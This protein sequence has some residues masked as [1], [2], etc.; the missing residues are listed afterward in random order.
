MTDATTPAARMDSRSCMLSGRCPRSDVDGHTVSGP[1]RR[2]LP[3]LYPPWPG[4][5]HEKL[6]AP[7]VR[8]RPTVRKISDRDAAYVRVSSQEKEGQALTQ[9]DHSTPATP[10]SDELP[11]FKALPDTTASIIS[12][13]RTSVCDVLPASTPA[14]VSTRVSSGLRTKRATTVKVSPMS[15]PCRNYLVPVGGWV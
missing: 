6:L 12:R 15:P 14:P 2:W 5:R 13:G 10:T 8:W 7:T 1:A 3:P 9:H 4:F 11:H